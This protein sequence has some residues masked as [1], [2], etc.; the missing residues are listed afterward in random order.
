MVAIWRVIRD[1]HRS[2]RLR[3]VGLTVL[4]GFAVGPALGVA[5]GARRTDTSFTRMLHRYPGPDLIIPN[6]PDPS[7]GTAVFDAATI[8][9]IPG[10]RIVAESKPLVSIIHGQ[11]TVSV[12]HV[13]P[14]LGTESLLPYKIVQ[15]R[16][17]DPARLDEVI[18]NYAT[19]QKLHLRTGDMVPLQLVP[20]FAEFLERPNMPLP[21]AVQIVGVY[22]GPSEIFSE[23][24]D[25]PLLHFSAA[26]AQRFPPNVA[27]GL[28]VALDHGPTGVPAFL[29]ELERRADG[30]RVQVNQAHQADRDKQHAI[31][32]EATALWLFAGLLA[33]TALLVVA[34]ALLRGATVEAADDRVLV[35]LG[36]TRGQ[37]WMRSMLRALLTLVAGAAGAIVVMYLA[38]PLFPVGVARLAEPVPGLGFD[39]PVAGVGAIAFVV[40]VLTAIAWPLHVLS[41]APLVQADRGGSGSTLAASSSWRGGLQSH[42]PLTLGL[43]ASLAFDRRKGPAPLAR[44]ATVGSMAAGI[45]GVTAAL[46]FATSLTHLL[47]NPRLYGLTW[48]AALSST[49]VDARGAEV[50]LR[51]DARVEGLAFGVT[52]V[53]F[54]INGQAVD[55]EL[56]DPP[57]KGTP[58]VVVLEGRAPSAAAEV[59]LGTRTMRDLHLRVG[60]I[61][62]GGVSGTPAGPIRVVGRVVLQPVNSGT[63]AGFVTAS[64]LRLGEGALA[65][66]SG[67][68]AAPGGPVPPAQAFLRFST[69]VDESV[70]LPELL[71]RIGGDAGTTTFTPPLDI[72]AFG[73]VRN[74]PRI[75]A[76]VLGGVSFL[77]L[78]HMLLVEARRRRRDLAIF[79]ALGLVRRDVVLVVVWQATLWAAIALAIGTIAG[80]VGGRWL[81]TRLVSGVEIVAEPR[82]SPLGL[83][84]VSG[85]VVFVACLVALGPGLLAGRVQPAVVLSAE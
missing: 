12:A 10:A 52:G 38:S 27:A 65:T 80:T 13:D 72:V 34:Q 23:E 47:Q 26:F 40:T 82:L 41:K 67:F 74:L 1:Q 2:A 45:A 64:A 51:G 31:R 49:T 7:G 75:F 29:A 8:R 14:E 85:V 79:K 32:A 54:R 84:G 77:T 4:I 66:Y 81:W 68:V 18:A 76:S 55:S 48:D 50:A 21:A 17:P 24:Q 56:I 9:G 63:R 43:G 59:A 28:L 5:A 44:R 58:S 25:V 3:F 11:P 83:A 16:Q 19:A 20:P 42:G 61:A 78:L 39:A 62:S 22:V 73:Q 69:G 71:Q 6:V 53:A 70:A 46:V 15:G 60:D 35:M 57:S 33:I 37:L 36:M 30:K